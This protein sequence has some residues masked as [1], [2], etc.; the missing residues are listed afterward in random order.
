MLYYIIGIIRG[1][2]PGNRG[3]QNF[4]R[5][6]HRIYV[7]EEANSEPVR[8]IS[9]YI[10]FEIKKFVYNSLY[11]MGTNLFIWFVPIFICADSV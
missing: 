7:T 8:C 11:Y 1:Q 2:T 3:T 5:Q 10:K 4:T 9:V 6:G